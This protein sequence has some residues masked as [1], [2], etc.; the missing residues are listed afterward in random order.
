LQ[1]LGNG[2]RGVDKSIWLRWLSYDLVAADEQGASVVVDDIR[3]LNEAEFLR[4]SGFVLIRLIGRQY[5]LDKAAAE[6]V[7]ETEMEKIECDHTL[8]AS[9]SFEEEIKNLNK[10]LAKI[11]ELNAKG[12]SKSRSGMAQS[13]MAMRLRDRHQEVYIS[14]KGFCDYG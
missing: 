5:K 14:E 2:A 3:Y 7:S 9:V 10:L 6:H 11:E 8:D 4:G 13:Y 12:K 1:A